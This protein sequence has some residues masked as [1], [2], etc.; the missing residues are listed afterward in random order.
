M[1][2]STP[3]PARIADC[4]TDGTD[5]YE[6]DQHL[7][8]LLVKA[9]PW[10]P[11]SVAAHRHCA[12]RAVES[13]ARGGI[14][15]FLDLGCGLPYSGPGTS[16]GPRHTYEAAK[17]FCTPHVAYVDCARLVTAH[18]RMMLA[19]RS[20]TVAV[21]ADV[22][23]VESLL[24]DRG[25]T[26]VIDTRRPVGVVCRDLLAWLTDQE[27]AA[28]T[29]GLH[30]RLAPGSALFVSHATTETAP[31][32]MRELTR[33]YAGYS[34]V[35]RPRPAGQIAQLLGPW[36]IVRPGLVPSDQWPGQDTA[37]PEPGQGHA[38]AAL[39]LHPAPN[40]PVLADPGYG[41]A[42]PGHP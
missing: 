32:A 27:A 31:A 21:Q 30:D 17:P 8:G 6:A 16:R 39:A 14:S 34:I 4:L 7:A 15:Q 1:T 26:G 41:P 2:V 42:A 24:T 33:L 25:L 18:A 5:N 28:L 19:T 13:M 40:T 38:H 11:Q 12:Q 23:H 36:T 37:R 10:L 9:A 3:H 29:T 20:G 22:R 35:F